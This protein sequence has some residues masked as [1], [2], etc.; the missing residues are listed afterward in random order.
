VTGVR[1]EPVFPDHHRDAA[2]P[3]GVMTAEW[4]RRVADALEDV[5]R[6]R[7]RRAGQTGRA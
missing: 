6:R 3:L 5:A 2:D 4:K 7:R 1:C